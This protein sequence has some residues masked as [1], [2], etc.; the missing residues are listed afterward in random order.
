[1]I[2]YAELFEFFI[3]A[4]DYWTPAFA[5]MTVA[6]LLSATLSRKGRG[7]VGVRFA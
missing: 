7:K 2:Q 4:G 5:S 1:M 3:G 6:Y